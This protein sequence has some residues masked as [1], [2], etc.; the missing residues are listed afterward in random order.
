M[1]YFGASYF[2]QTDALVAQAVS[3]QPVIVSQDALPAELLLGPVKEYLRVYDNEHDTVITILVE[4]AVAFAE[5]YTRQT[6]RARVYRWVTE[7]QM[8][9]HLPRFPVISLNSVEVQSAGEWAEVSAEDFAKITVSSDTPPMLVPGN[10]L[11]E[12]PL[13]VTWKAG[14]S[15]EWP[16]DLIVLIWQMVEEN[17]RRRGAS[18]D[19]AQAVTFSRAFQLALE[20]FAT[21]H[22]AVR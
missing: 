19:G 8:P 2:D 7:N 5:T 11:L 10:I 6:F 16:R 20:Q 21:H 4:A 1:S 18:P 3:N 15:G 14:I 13:R 22:D 12:M 17:F 9:V